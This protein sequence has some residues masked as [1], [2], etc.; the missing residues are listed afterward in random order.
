MLKCLSVAL[1][2]TI[3][4][5][6]VVF[7][8]FPQPTA[9]QRKAP[10][11]TF[12]SFSSSLLTATKVQHEKRDLNAFSCFFSRVVID[13][14]IKSWFKS[15]A[16]LICGDRLNI[17]EDSNK[18]NSKM[19]SFLSLIQV[20]FEAKLV[21]LRPISTVCFFFSKIW[22]WFVFSQILCWEFSMQ[23]NLRRVK[24]KEMILTLLTV[25]DVTSPA[26]L[27]FFPSHY[28]FISGLLPELSLQ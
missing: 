16:G 9:K 12:C 18:S 24:E 1:R 2:K 6:P 14:V 17:S 3:D 22:F 5:H 23:K 4:L 20:I 7:V 8:K 13:S 19:T 27:I 21:F 15:S 28:S 10:G 11:V 26:L 25:F